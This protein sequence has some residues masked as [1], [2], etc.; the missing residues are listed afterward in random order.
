MR[1]QSGLLRRAPVERPEKPLL[2]RGYAVRWSLEEELCTWVGVS[3]GERFDRGDALVWA[4]AEF[5]G[6]RRPA[7]GYGPTVHR[8]TDAPTPGVHRWHDAPTAGV[9]RWRGG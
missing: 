6:Y 1:P 7:A 8:W 2:D 5:G 4:V 3:S 9:H